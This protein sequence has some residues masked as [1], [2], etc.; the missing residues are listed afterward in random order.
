MSITNQEYDS[1]TKQASPGTK[2][3]KTIPMA[4]LIGGLICVLGQAFINLYIW[5][6]VD[7]QTA[8]T[9]G[10]MTLIFIA[11]LLTGLN[12]F[13]NIAKVAGAGTLV[14]ITGF[15]NAVV[16]PA[17]E[18]KSEGYVLGLGAKMFVIAGPVIV[19]GV[20]ASVVYGLI[21]FLFGLV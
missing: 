17:L 19:Y 4:F 12:M 16:S 18:F 3:Y 15:S 20:V 14:P 6:G 7:Q 10:S 2:S 11:A 8:S 5:L 9:L 13:D 21:L 1:L